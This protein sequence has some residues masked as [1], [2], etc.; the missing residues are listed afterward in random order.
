MGRT[1]SGRGRRNNLA[2]YKGVIGASTGGCDV[3][4]HVARRIVG[5]VANAFTQGWGR[6]GIEGVADRVDLGGA[7]GADLHSF[8][9]DIWGTCHAGILAGID[10]GRIMGY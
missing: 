9:A 2:R 6:G 5:A 1:G 3:E 8:I 10:E 4:I 7:L